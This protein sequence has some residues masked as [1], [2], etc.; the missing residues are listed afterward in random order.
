MIRLPRGWTARVR[1]HG[2]AA[3]LPCNFIRSFSRTAAQRNQDK[4]S[5][6]NVEELLSRPTW[7]V[8]S[9]F[10]YDA[11]TQA[12]EVTP[13]QLHHL[14]RLSAL[15]SPKDEAEEA[16]MLSILCSQLHFVK[17]IQRVDTTNINPL[18]SLRDE[19]AAGEQETE[20]GIETLKEA[21]AVEDVLGRHHRRI[22]RR[23]VR[24]DGQDG[25]EWDILSSAER[26]VG[27]YFVVNGGKDG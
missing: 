7:S 9:L 8:Y 14:L 6:V 11:T 26:K 23:N 1:I 3:P 21:F 27:R 13:K 2:P 15:P 19:T 20:I 10:P 24:N 25:P 5:A 18:Q 17:E 4:D 16:Q 22:R 12:S